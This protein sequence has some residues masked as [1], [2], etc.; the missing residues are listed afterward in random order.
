MEGLTPEE[1]RGIPSSTVLAYQQAL[2]ERGVNNM[3]HL[4]GITSSAHT[5]EDVE[6]TLKAI[7]GTIGQLM[8]DGLV[9]RG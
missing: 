9:G 8:A 3:S 6:I 4:G 1:I 5:D 7:E 2:L